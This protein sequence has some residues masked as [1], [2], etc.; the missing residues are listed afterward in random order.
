VQATIGQRRAR[1]KQGRRAA[2]V[3][4]GRQTI[5]GKAGRNRVPLSTKGLGRGRD[6]VEL[7]A[8]AGGQPSAATKL[9]FAYRNSR[10]SPSK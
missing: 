6:T 5:A 1:R 9:G 2:L 7:V 4:R 3:V 8:S 10:K